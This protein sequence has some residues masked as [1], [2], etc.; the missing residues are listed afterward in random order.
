M[1]D[2]FGSDFLNFSFSSLS[3]NDKTKEWIIEASGTL[4][5]QTLHKDAVSIIVIGDVTSTADNAFNGYLNLEYL[6]IPDSVTSIGN[7][8]FANTLVRKFRI[9]KNLINLSSQFSFDFSPSLEEFIV[10]PECIHYSGIEGVLFDKSQT[11]LIFYP[12]GKLDKIYS[13]PFGIKTISPN[14][15]VD[16][17]YLEQLV[18]PQ[19]ITKIGGGLAIRTP[20]LK[21]IVIY[22]FKNDTGSLFFSDPATNFE[23]LNINSSAIKYIY[24]NIYVLLQHKSI[25]FIDLNDG[26]SQ[27]LPDFNEIALDN[28][29]IGTLGIYKFMKC[30][31]KICPSYFNLTNSFPFIFFILL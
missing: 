29:T 6:E 22:R 4:T 28:I 30:S 12:S 25:K 16:L 15:F 18:F 23:S 21:S 8:I 20:V 14:S 24:T 1:S 27:N 7:N 19:S 5:K 13:V 31:I 26:N 11:N 17:V 9:P 2:F 10:D 3:W